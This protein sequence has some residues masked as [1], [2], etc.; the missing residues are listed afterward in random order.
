MAEEDVK[1][2][3]EGEGAEGEEGEDEEGGKGPN[4]LFLI[5]GVLLV[6]LIGGGAVAYFTGALD[7]LLGKKTDTEET[8]ETEEEP[9][10]G[11]DG[12]AAGGPYFM[13]VSDIIVNL[14]STGPNPRFLKLKV[15]IEVASEADLARIEQVSPRVI[16]HFQTYLRELRVEDLKGSAGIYR[17]RQEL[18]RRVNAAA[19]PVE[20]KDV[21]FQEIL[22]Q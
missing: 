17:L 22:I 14:N 4:K 3:E 8:A 12:D 20:V 15:Q 7:G 6:L 2:N 5:I 19:Y 21:L 13:E 10:A 1:E 18:L 9:K 16:D 11:K